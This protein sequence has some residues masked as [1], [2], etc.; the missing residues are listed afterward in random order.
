M[1]RSQIAILAVAGSL[2]IILVGG[3]FVFA[4]YVRRSIK[5]PGGK[6][7]SSA[8]AA[9]SEPAPIASSKALEIA[10]E[11]ADWEKTFDILEGIYRELVYG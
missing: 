3:F 6:A 11:R 1:D 4:F 9:P 10:R 8:P 2:L 5:R 7:A